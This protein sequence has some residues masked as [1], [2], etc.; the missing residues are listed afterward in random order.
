MAECSNTDFEALIFPWVVGCSG[1]WKLKKKE[2]K[3]K[4][5]TNNVMEWNILLTQWK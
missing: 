1:I 5:I 4:D 3:K 2:R